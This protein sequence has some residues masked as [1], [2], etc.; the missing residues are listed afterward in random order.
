MGIG[1]FFSRA[2]DTGAAGRRADEAG[3]ISAEA[4][5]Q[6][7]KDL[8]KYYGEAKTRATDQNTANANWFNN[9]EGYAADLNTLANG[10]FDKQYGDANSAYWASMQRYADQNRLGEAQYLSQLKQS[11]RDYTGNIGRYNQQFGL[12]EGQVAKE[13]MMRDRAYDSALPWQTG[14]EGAYNRA[15]YLAG[16][17]FNDD[18]N[19]QNALT[20]TRR[21]LLARGL[22]GNAGAMAEANAMNNYDTGYRQQQIGNMTSLASLGKTVWNP[23]AA[24]I[25]PAP[26]ASFN[27]QMV[28]D[29]R[30]GLSPD[31]KGN[32]MWGQGLNPQ[33]YRMGLS[34]P[35][36]VGL[37][38]PTQFGLK[39]VD[40]TMQG[41]ENMANA[42]IAKGQAQAA[43]TAMWGNIAA[44]GVGG[45]TGGLGGGLAAGLVTKR[46]GT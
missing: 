32:A 24:T 27:S 40:T 42:K 37:T 44:A 13:D 22:G 38:L 25:T 43:N 19:R 28:N 20:G 23:N 45:F 35:Q 7:K 10:R 9:Q 21:A 15:L 8:E 26:D 39:Q 29:A 11:D 33:D 31:I 6:A 1:K 18:I 12:L 46:G 17:P 14:S 4:A 2:F 16:N 34:N 5:A 41:G 30:I 3:K 36:D